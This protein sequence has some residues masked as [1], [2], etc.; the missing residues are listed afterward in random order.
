MAKLPGRRDA[1]GMAALQE[2]LEGTLAGLDMGPK[3]REQTALRAWE[4]V[5]GRV[6]GTHA[7]AEA[8]RDGVLIVLTDSPAWAQELHM[9]EAELLAR[10]RSL[11]GEDA[12]DGIHFSSGLR[13]PRQVRPR[14]GTPR[15]ETLSLRR[16]EEVRAAAARIDDEEL[17]LRAEKA[18][19]SLERIRTWRRRRG[20]RRCA[21][22]GQWQRTGRRWCASCAYERGE[23]P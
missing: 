8:M 19:A 13:H 7:R 9:R 23:G 1:G 21:R 11:L 14:E 3:L 15:E 5:V 2:L 4:Q 18:F 12:V 20:W 17:R 22:C 6:V 10:L 16:A